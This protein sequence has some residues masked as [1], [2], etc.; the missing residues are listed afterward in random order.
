V[1]AARLD[2]ALY[3][4]LDSIMDDLVLTELGDGETVEE[5]RTEFIA[6]LEKFSLPRFRH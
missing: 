1:N 3:Y 5:S 2:R 6:A 4:E